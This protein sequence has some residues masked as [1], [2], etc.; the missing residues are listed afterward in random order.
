MRTC[1][2]PIGLGGAT[3]IARSM[4][5]TTARSYT[6]TRSSAR[7]RWRRRRHAASA[8]FAPNRPP[9][10]CVGRYS[11]RETIF[12]YPGG[13]GT[14]ESA[15]WPLDVCIFYP[16]TLPFATIFFRPDFYAFVP[17][18]VLT[19]VHLTTG[20]LTNVSSARSTSRTSD[21]NYFE[22]VARK[23]YERKS[24]L[25]RSFGKCHVTRR[26]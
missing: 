2:P 6:R 19:F 15:A 20:V 22:A 5:M 10:F 4:G 7:T 16:S 23:L 18:I 24:C 17:P 26:T 1:D 9:L 14:V 13:I 8:L 21:E 12:R 3:T 11:F 25:R